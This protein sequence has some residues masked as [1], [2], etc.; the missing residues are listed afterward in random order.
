MSIYGAMTVCQALCSV[1]DAAVTTTDSVW[2]RESWASPS[3]RAWQGQG[4]TVLN[5]VNESL[6]PLTVCLVFSP[7][8]RQWVPLPPGA[9]SFSTWKRRW[10]PG[11]GNSW[12]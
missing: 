12:E 8:L 2:T 1:P 7:E 10:L 4:H 3:H 9:D 11:L 6:G 5:W